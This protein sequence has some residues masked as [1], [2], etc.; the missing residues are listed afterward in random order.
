MNIDSYLIAS[1]LMSGFLVSFCGVYLFLWRSIGRTVALVQIPLAVHV[2][3]APMAP[4][5]ATWSLHGSANGRSFSLIQ[6][7]DPVVVS[8]AITA[9]FIYLLSPLASG[10]C[11]PISGSAGVVVNLTALLA[12]I[13]GAKTLSLSD[14]EGLRQLLYGGLD[15]VPSP[16]SF[17]AILTTISVVLML[18]RLF[19]EHFI[20][21][22]M[23]PTCTCGVL[24]RED[25]WKAVLFIMLGIGIAASIPFLGAMFTISLVVIPPFLA[26]RYFKS[27]WLI[28]LSS[29]I[30][31]M[32]MA[33]MALLFR[34]Y[35][36]VSG[37]LSGTF[38][39]A[40]LLV[41]TPDGRGR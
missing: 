23:C 36:G 9:L 5:M 4:A 14:P 12:V 10:K 15:T 19:P 38:F 6:S 11:Y 30:L 37:G 16:D 2:F 28:F 32:S 26:A 3:L 39:G 31:G 20:S 7:I 29:A 27:S 33:G 40:M 1:W 34:Y 21:V 35:L 8:L 24:V 22:L 41:L 18:T 13:L 17:C 25:R